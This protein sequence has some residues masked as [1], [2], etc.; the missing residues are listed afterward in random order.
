MTLLTGRNRVYLLLAV[1]AL[2]ALLAVGWATLAGA[3]EQDSGAENTGAADSDSDAPYDGPSGIWVSGT[4]KASSEPDVAVISVGVES[5][6]DTAASARAKAASAMS[7]V[8]SALTRIGIASKDIRTS[9]FNISPRYQWVEVQR[10]EG[11]GDSE[12]EDGTEGPEELTCYD[13]SENRLVGYSVSNQLSVKI[14]NLSN[15][16]KIIDQATKAAGDMVRV[17][18]I[19]FD[20]EDPQPLQDEARENAVQ[21]LKRKAEMLAELSGVKLGRLVYINEQSGYVPPQP[22]Y[23]RAESMAFA[24]D[25]GMDTT[26]SGGELEISVTVQGVFLIADD[27]D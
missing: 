8:R 9:Y 25:A 27:D 26:I 21:D 11:G 18:G 12:K 4:G 20:V 16:G 17:N 2:A 6:E 19:S 7:K 5:V 13:V 23:V 15:S 1:L 14:R 22:L 10:C 24:A 3:Q